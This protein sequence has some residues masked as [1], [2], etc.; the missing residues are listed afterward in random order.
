MG[1][2]AKG[3][4]D[5]LKEGMARAATDA[6]EVVANKKWDENGF[7][8]A[9]AVKAQAWATPCWSWTSFRGKEADLEDNQPAIK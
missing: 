2:I 4:N 3:I 8:L 9:K 6:S 5:L 7:S 1:I